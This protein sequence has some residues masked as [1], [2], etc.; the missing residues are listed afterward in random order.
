MTLSAGI[1]LLSLLYSWVSEAS[2]VL[3][4]AVVYSPLRCFAVLLERKER[5]CPVREAL[6]E[7][8]SQAAFLGKDFQ[9]KLRK[10]SL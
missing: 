7:E 1:C 5:R 6:F 2:F 3:E 4:K 10:I 8:I 9:K